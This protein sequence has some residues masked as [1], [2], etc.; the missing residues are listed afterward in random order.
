MAETLPQVILLS[1]P[2]EGK[3]VLTLESSHSEMAGH[4]S[5][6][7]AA[8]CLQHFVLPSLG[9]HHTWG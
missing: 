4:A 5:K 7:K 2:Q 3:T 6:T 9:E 8:F 1:P